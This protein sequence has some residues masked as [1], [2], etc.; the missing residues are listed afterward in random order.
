MKNAH[1]LRYTRSSSLRPFRV[2]RYPKGSHSSEL[3]K[4]CI[5]AFLITPYIV[6][7]KSLNSKA[8]IQ[9]GNMQGFDSL[10][11]MLVWAGIFMVGVG[12]FLWFGDKIPWLGKLP[13]D[14]LIKKEKFTFYFPLVTCI[15]ISLILTLLFSIFKK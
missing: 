8:E 5:W 13:G 11:K 10:G 2:P 7:N 12:L 9:V 6:S 3:R 15:L 1:L 4:P 14:I